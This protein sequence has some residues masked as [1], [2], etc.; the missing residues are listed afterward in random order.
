MFTYTSLIQHWFKIQDLYYDVHNNY[1]EAVK[2]QAPFNNAI[3]TVETSYSD[4][5]C[6]GQI[7][8]YKQKI[9][10]PKF[11]FNQITI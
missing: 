8:H 2:S 1:I 9:M 5:V 6:P 4:H 7:D 3:C 10:I 11:F